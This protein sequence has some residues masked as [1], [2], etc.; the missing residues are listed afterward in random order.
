MKK[1]LLL[2]LLVSGFTAFSAFSA[3]EYKSPTFKFVAQPTAT[4]KIEKKWSKG[5]Q[6]RVLEQP[7][8]IREIASEKEKPKRDPASYGGRKVQKIKFVAEPWLYTD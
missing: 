1:L 2:S 6:F 7:I 5:T 4:V 3:E 8:L